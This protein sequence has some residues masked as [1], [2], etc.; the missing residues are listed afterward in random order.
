MKGKLVLIPFPFTD[1]TSTKLRPALV[2][3]EG[4][5]DVI[6]AFIS[7]KMPEKPARHDVIIEQSH[8]EY[9]LTGLKVPSVVKLDKVATVLKSLILGE[10]GELGPILKG[11]VNR[12]TRELFRV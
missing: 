7:S 4:R 1:L 12:R 11:E 6:V 9:G 5:A 3:Y 8:P 10:I 2:I